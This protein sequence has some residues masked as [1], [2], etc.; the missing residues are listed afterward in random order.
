MLYDTNRHPSFLSP[1]AADD[2]HVYQIYQFSCT[3]Y[4][5]GAWVQLYPSTGSLDIHRVVQNN[6]G[7]WQYTITKPGLSGTLTGTVNLP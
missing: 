5:G 6:A 3:N 2:F 1:Y 4:R 7:T